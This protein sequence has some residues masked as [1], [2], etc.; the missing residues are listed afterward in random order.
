[1]PSDRPTEAELKAKRNACYE[2][3]DVYTQCLDTHGGDAD[4]CRHELRLFKAACPASWVGHFIR[5]HQFSKFKENVERQGAQA[6]DE[7]RRPQQ[8]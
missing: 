2:A 3:R 7:A 8:Q 5:K 6:T 4:K 1:M